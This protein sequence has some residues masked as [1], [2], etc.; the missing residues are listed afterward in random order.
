VLVVPDA[1][2]KTISEAIIETKTETARDFI[3][4]LRLE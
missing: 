1:E 4:S 3:R 2:G